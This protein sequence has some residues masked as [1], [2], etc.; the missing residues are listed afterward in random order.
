MN[1]RE[2][3]ERKFQGWN[4]TPNGGR[5]YWRDRPGHHGWAR[6]QKE[7]DSDENT[8]RFW[9]EIYN[10]SNE[11]IE[12]HHKFPVDTGHRNVEEKR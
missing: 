6:Y 5:T 2:E 10:E 12:I 8:L 3:N 11:L 1:K 4:A 9:Q 7:C